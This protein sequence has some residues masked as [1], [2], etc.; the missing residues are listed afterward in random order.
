[1]IR[2]FREM[3]LPEYRNHYYAGE[4]NENGYV[5]D[6]LS[7]V[8]KHF[9]G[10]DYISYP[11]DFGDGSDKA[12]PS[13]ESHWKKD[14]QIEMF[15]HFHTPE[16]TK[17][18]YASG[19]ERGR[20]HFP[21]LLSI[22]NNDSMRRY[23]VP[24]TP[25]SDLSSHSLKFVNNLQRRGIVND[26]EDNIPNA[27]TNNMTFQKYPSNKDPYGLD[28]ISDIDVKEGKEAL[29]K[30]LRR[31]KNLS[32]QFDNVETHQQLELDL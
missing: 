19:T 5:D 3:G 15:N 21:L 6:H 9:S 29:R 11:D 31:P 13:W 4:D 1:M 18:A 20:T 8:T 28:Q 32:N 22:A 14:Q 24:L 12:R 30:L 27:P 17:V 7:I 2:Y 23:G 25:D 16:T 26:L 10:R